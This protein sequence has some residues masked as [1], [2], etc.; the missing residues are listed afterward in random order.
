MPR[1][2]VNKL[3]AFAVLVG[4]AAWMGT[5][6]FSTVGSAATEEPG[7]PAE[8]EQPKAAPRTVAVV[9]APHMQHARAIRISGQTEPDKRATLAI[10]VMGIIKDLP[11][12][13]GQHVN[14]GDLVMRL[15]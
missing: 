10:R 15:D 14:R 6:K 3:I 11:V 12:K 2:R 9:K 8:V 13:Q 5:G 1:V 7:K 4:F